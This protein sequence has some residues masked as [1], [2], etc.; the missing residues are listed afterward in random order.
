MYHL[1]R[2]DTKF[3]VGES[4]AIRQ[5]TDIT[6]IAT[7]ETVYHALM[8]AVEIEKEGLTC[9][10]ISMH[11]IKPLDTEAILRAASDS[12]A[13]MTVEEHS[14]SG[15]LGE[16]CAAVLMEAGLSVPFRIVGFPDEYMV[17][18][19]QPEIFDHYGISG[20]GLAETAKTLLNQ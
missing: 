7:G 20:R 14:V 9:R 16:A 10:V 5:G 13:L 18:G 11:T 19:S 2:P 12:R 15:G 6:F 3:E 8:A 1:H 17:A 4:I